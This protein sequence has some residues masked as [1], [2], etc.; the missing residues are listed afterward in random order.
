MPSVLIRWSVV[1]IATA[2]CGCIDLRT[3]VRVNSDGSGEIEEQVLF[4][5]MLS[6]MITRFDEASVLDPQALT[7][8]A[9][10]M[11][12]GVR[13]REAKA[14]SNGKRNGYRARFS[15]SDINQ[16]QLD[17]NPTSRSPQGLAS[18]DVKMMAEREPIRFQFRP[19][20]LARLSI[21]MPRRVGDVANND[22]SAVAPKSTVGSSNAAHD[23]AIE[24]AMNLFTDV[25]KQMRIVFR[26]VVDGSI[27]TTN[28]SHVQGMEVTLVELDFESLLADAERLSDFAR[29]NPTR[30]SHAGQLLS[31]LPGVTV[32]LEPTV[33]IEFKSSDQSTQ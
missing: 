1:A 27:M 31:D 32:E 10:N 8:Q 2:L 20:E 22:T 24:T 17:Q 6:E 12:R 28:A 23:V 18:D 14:L 26:V 33:F 4:G 15:F 25:L 5:E 3:T 21:L 11:G 7:T 9:K 13:L 16:L 29:H 30:I 19:G